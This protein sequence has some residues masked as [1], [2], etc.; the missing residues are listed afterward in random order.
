MWWAF[1]SFSF[2]LVKSSISSAPS[3]PVAGW[4]TAVTKEAPGAKQRSTAARGWHGNRIWKLRC[5]PRVQ[6]RC[7]TGHGERAGTTEAGTE[8]EEEEEEEEGLG[9][10]SE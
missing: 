1:F 4:Q 5:W 7:R 10:R 8:E 3:L 9:G 6:S 2:F